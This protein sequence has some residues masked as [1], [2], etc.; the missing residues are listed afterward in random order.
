MKV[1]NFTPNEY[2]TVNFHPRMINDIERFCVKKKGIFSVDTTFEVCDGL[3]L[4]DTCYP[5]MSLIKEDRTHPEFPGPSFWHFRRFASE[6]VVERP[7]LLQLPIIGHDL[8]KAQMLGFHDIFSTSSHALCTQHIKGRDKEQLRQRNVNIKNTGRILADIYGTQNEI[9]LQ[10]GLADSLDE[11]DFV[12]KL[13]SLKDIWEDIVPGF[14]E[15]FTANRSEV[16]IECLTI[17]A[18]R[19]LNIKDRYYTNALG[20]KHKLQKKKIFEAGIHKEIAAVSKQLNDWC[21]EYYREGERAIRGFGRYRLNEEY[22]H[23][24]RTPTEWNQMSAK[25]QQNL[26]KKFYEY[27]PG[28]T[29]YTKPNGAGKKVGDSG[30]K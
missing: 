10:N 9:L 22:K 11:E 1:V 13:E 27:T 28:V 30:K 29:L 18:R 16:F 14:H 3:L 23:F 17:E 5:N 15:W 21:N 20:N 6:L 12:T 4:T 26:L 8:D 7:L 24:F 25:N 2:S 19:N